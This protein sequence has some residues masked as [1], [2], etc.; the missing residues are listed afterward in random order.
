MRSID[1]AIGAVLGVTALALSATSAE[2]LVINPVF[3]SSITSLSNAST[4][5]SAFRAAASLYSAAFSDSSTINIQ[6]SWGKVGDF[7]MPSSALGASLDW[8]YGY[9]SYSQ[10]RSLLGATVGSA[11]DKGGLANLPGSVGAPSNFV[12]PAAEAKALGIVSGSASGID[13]YI[14]FAG[15][16]TSTYNYGSTIAR[17]KYDFTAVAAHEIAEVLGRLSGL[18]DTSP[19]WRTPFDLFRYSAPGV[20]SFSYSALAYLSDDGGKTSL[21]IF[22]NSSS[23]GDR[24]DWRSSASTRDVQDAFLYPGIKMPLT[25]ADLIGLDLIGY[26]V[27]AT[28]TVSQARLLN[29]PSD[30]N[31][32]FAAPEPDAIELL[33]AGIGGLAL[34]RRR[35]AI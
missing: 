4:V 22:N 24:G 34:L 29:Q 21:G 31:Y 35:H 16:S 26:D 28:L 13:G 32:F 17:G 11:V 7:S 30:P 15:S 19:N 10:I 33:A 3:D 23:G 25:R 1:R 20:P 9:Y 14:G 27:P 5:E 12:I 8:L 6:V 2:A 18:E